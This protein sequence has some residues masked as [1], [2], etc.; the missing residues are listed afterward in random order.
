VLLH[1][2]VTGF[3]GTRSILNLDA[4]N[5]ESSLHLSGMESSET[6]ADCKELLKRTN[7]GESAS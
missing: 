4:A 3:D 2:E 7:A 5:M 6:G 1:F